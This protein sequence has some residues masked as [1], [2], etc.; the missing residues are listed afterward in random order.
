MRRSIVM[1]VGF[2]G[3]TFSGCTK[4]ESNVPKREAYA[5]QGFG[6]E[7]ITL[8]ISRCGDMTETPIAKVSSSSKIQLTAYLG[9]IDSGESAEITFYE[10]ITSSQ[11][12]ELDTETPGPL[13]LGTHTFY[14]SAMIRRVDGASYGPICTADKSVIVVPVIIQADVVDRPPSGSTYASGVNQNSIVLKLN[15]TV[16]TP[17]IDPIQDGYH[18]YYEPTSGQI[19]SGTNTVFIRCFDLANDGAPEGTSKDEYGNEMTYSWNFTRP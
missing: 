3:I 1:L 5:K 13:S 15:G 16:V 12:T 14:A 7:S 19:S 4:E 9:G 11:V 10:R 17:K 6:N 18:I 2:L 8:V